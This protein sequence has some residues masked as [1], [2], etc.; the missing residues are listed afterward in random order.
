MLQYTSRAGGRKRGSGAGRAGWGARPDGHCRGAAGFKKVGRLPRGNVYQKNGFHFGKRESGEL[1]ASRET[2][3]V[4]SKAET[5]PNTFTA[6][7]ESGLDGF[8]A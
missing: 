6:D 7:L 3:T 5:S 8:G 1:L 2:S 4:N